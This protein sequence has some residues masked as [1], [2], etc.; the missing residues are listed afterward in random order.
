M[1]LANLKKRGMANLRRFSGPPSPAGDSSRRTWPAV[2][3]PAS[4]RRI[5]NLFV[6]YHASIHVNRRLQGL[7]DGLLKLRSIPI[8]LI[9]LRISS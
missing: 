5:Q 9:F 6:P 7:E 3:G 1:V 2:F 8:S 4:D